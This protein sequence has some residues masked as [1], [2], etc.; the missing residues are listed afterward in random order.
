MIQK[1]YLLT[2]ICDK[3]LG[4]KYRVFA[5]LSHVKLLL[6]VKI[7]IGHKQR[8]PILAQLLLSYKGILI[9]EIFMWASYNFFDSL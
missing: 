1:I 3:L 9:I 4:S 5:K 6:W 7:S 8:H 2:S